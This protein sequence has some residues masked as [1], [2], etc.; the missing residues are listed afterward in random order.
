MGQVDER[1]EDEMDQDNQ[2]Y[3]VRIIKTFEFQ[4][5]LR[6]EHQINL[7]IPMVPNANLL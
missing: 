3:G 7:N 2:D 5:S 6:L 1:D 4:R